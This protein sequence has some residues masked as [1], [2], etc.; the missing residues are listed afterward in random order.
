M[1]HFKYAKGKAMHTRFAFS[2]L[3]VSV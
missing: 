3:R 1:P 2:D